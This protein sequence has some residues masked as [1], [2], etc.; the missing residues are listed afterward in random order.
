MRGMGGGI[1]ERGLGGGL[2]LEF[3]MIHGE[4]VFFFCF[5]IFFCLHVGIFRWMIIYPPWTPP[6]S[7]K[8]IQRGL[9]STMDLPNFSVIMI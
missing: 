9:L 6:T 7:T 8:I 3:F 5:P 1:T 4:G 2:L